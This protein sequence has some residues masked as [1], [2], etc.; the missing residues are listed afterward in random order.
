MKK[1]LSFLWSILEFVIIVYVIVMF[2]L[3]LEEQSPRRQ[4]RPAVIRHILAA[5]CVD[6]VHIALQ[7]TIIIAV[8]AACADRKAS[9]TLDQSVAHSNLIERRFQVVCEVAD[10]VLCLL[11]IAVVL[12]ER[13]YDLLGAASRAPAV[14]EIGQQLLCLP[15]LKF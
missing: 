11:E 6:R 9:P 15:A 13:R 3:R 14:N 12:P 1:V 2:I 4:L 7:H 5:I 8:K 10:P